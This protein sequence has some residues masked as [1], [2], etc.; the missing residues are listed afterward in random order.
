M[1][2][3]SVQTTRRGGTGVS[4]AAPARRDPN[5]DIRASGRAFTVASWIVLILFAILWL[6]PSFWAIKTSLTANSTSA[7]GAGI[8]VVCPARMWREL[9]SGTPVSPERRLPVPCA[10]M[11]GLLGERL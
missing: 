11:Q 4:A 3:D 8:L 10:T 1:S 7:L 9:I 2:S 5:A 6:I